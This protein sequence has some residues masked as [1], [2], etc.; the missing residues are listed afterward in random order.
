MPSFQSSQ[1]LTVSMSCLF[2][3]GSPCQHCCNP[4]L[5]SCLIFF[6]HMFYHAGWI[7]WHT[8]EET[9]SGSENGHLVVIYKLE[10]HQTQTLKDPH[11]RTHD[12]L[13]GRWGHNPGRQIR[14]LFL[15][16]PG[17]A[18]FTVVG[19][20]L[21]VFVVWGFFALFWFFFSTIWW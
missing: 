1:G 4:Q 19:G 5:I 20:F 14:K 2:L 16:F 21:I 11:P 15:D 8:A 7:S 9:F 3:L 10:Q 12:S 13:P 6:P 17:S 18:G